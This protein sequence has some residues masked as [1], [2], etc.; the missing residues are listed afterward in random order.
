VI[1]EDVTTV[2]EGAALTFTAGSDT[3]GATF[4]WTVLRDGGLVATGDGPSL[5]L[6]AEDDGVYRVE[7]TATV[8]GVTGAAA[9]EEFTALN[10]AP[11]SP[12]PGPTPP[13]SARPTR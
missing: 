7:L 12:S 8:A 9:V 13:P 10:V 11:P 4:A 6:V 5:D 1:I 3:P 2:D